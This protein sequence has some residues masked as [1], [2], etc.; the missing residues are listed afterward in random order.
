MARPLIVLQSYQRP[1][2][3]TNPYIVMLG[4]SLAALTDV[5]VLTFTWRRALTARF[6]VFHMHWPEVRIGG[7]TAPRRIAHQTL[8]ALL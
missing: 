2:N 1:T 8:F 4:E 5:D 3:T 7:R 6:D